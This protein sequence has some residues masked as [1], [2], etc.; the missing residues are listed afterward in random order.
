MDDLIDINAPI[1]QEG[2]K[3]TVR[4]WL[5]KI[6]ETVKS[7]DPLVELETDKVTQEVPAPAD[8]IL[9]EILM[10]N[11]D[12]A[13]P[14]AVLGRIG[15]ETPGREPPAAPAQGVAKSAAQSP[16]FSPAVRHAAEEYGIDPTT[17]VGSGRDGRVTRADMDRAFAERPERHAP[18]SEAK[19]TQPPSEIEPAD[20]VVTLRSRK[21]PHSGM[22]S[23][24][25]AHMLTSVTTAPHVTA[26]FE[27]DFSA[28]MR[29]RDANK[30]RLAAEGIA[31]S[32]TA[33]VV[34]ACVSAMRAVPEVNSRWH[35][36]ALEVFDDINIGVGT[37]LGDKGLIAPVIHQAQDLSFAEIA[38]K[39]QDL[40]A[41]A[42]ANALSPA[43]VRG[44][45]FT[46]SN[47]GVSGSLL[48]APIII[49]Q[50]QSAILGVGKLEKR[51]VVREI[52]GVDTIQ[53]RPT[54]YVSLTIDHRALDGHQ[55]NMWLTHF[56]QTLETWPQ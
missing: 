3:A 2:T 48:A 36:D 16:H 34:S 6:G 46:I 56:V 28:V 4:N 20:K 26:V 5:K 18:A 23:S 43:E 14:G 35:E 8:G 53:V 45:T 38:A 30:A 12:D 32:Y 39:L 52:D 51:V 41:R 24:I 9:A 37:A 25:A 22:R 21:I 31:L 47:H 11:G 29:H 44:G 17:I 19:P 55:T 27:A 33:Y 1:E 7:G 10:E 42:R 15:S 54:A 50:P 40:T 49:N 13:V